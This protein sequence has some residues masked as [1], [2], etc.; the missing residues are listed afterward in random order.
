MDIKIYDDYPFRPPS[1][2]FTTKVY[3]P[4]ISENGSI[5]LDLLNDKWTSELTIY[6]ALMGIKSLLTDPNWDN[7]QVQEASYLYKNDKAKYD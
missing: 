7:P 2:K 4:N 1:F 5:S 3:H 6:K